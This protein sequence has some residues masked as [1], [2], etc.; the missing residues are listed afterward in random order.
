M[1]CFIK[2]DRNTCLLFINSVNIE[3]LN[4]LI[5]MVWPL[6]YFFW[7]G[8]LILIKTIRV[9]FVWKASMAH[10]FNSLLWLFHRIL[11]HQGSWEFWCSIEITMESLDLTGKN[12][13]AGATFLTYLKQPR[14]TCPQS[15][16]QLFLSWWIHFPYWSGKCDNCVIVPCQ[17]HYI[18]K[19]DI[20][21][22]IK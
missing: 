4:K 20:L 10:H 2:V 6:I 17:F 21:I 1:F 5:L 13:T 22:S 18:F 14:T 9:S 7:G 3:I 16:S 11:L 19:S 15:W 12:S 8:T